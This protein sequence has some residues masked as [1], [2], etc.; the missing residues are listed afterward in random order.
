MYKAYY[1][2][3]ETGLTRVKWEYVFRRCSIKKM[4][5][6]NSQNSQENT[7]ARVSFLMKLQGS[8]YNFIKKRDSGKGVF[9]WQ[10]FSKNQ[11]WAYLWINSIKCLYNLCFFDRFYCMSSWELSKNSYRKIL[12]LSSKPFAFTSYYLKN[13]NMS[14]TS[15]PALCSAWFWKKNISLFNMCIKMVC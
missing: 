1:F 2:C 13:K 7:C 12:Q 14:R 15:L 3:I 4:F 6:E 8:A 9:F 10:P 11:N 5:W